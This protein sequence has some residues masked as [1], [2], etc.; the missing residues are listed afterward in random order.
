MSMYFIFIIEN[1]TVLEVSGPIEIYFIG[2]GQD[3]K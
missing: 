3:G 2:F 1:V